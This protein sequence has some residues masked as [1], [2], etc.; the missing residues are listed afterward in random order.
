MTEAVTW[1]L[2]AG[3]ISIDV[4]LVWAIVQTSKT[5]HDFRRIFAAIQMVNNPHERLRLLYQMNPRRDFNR[6]LWRR[7]TFRDPMQ[8]HSPEIRGLLDAAQASRTV[9]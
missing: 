3:A 2:T 5:G 8:A 6:H 7:I 9:H 1:I 4:W